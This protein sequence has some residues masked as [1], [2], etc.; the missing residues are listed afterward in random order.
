[1]RRLARRTG[2]RVQI[3]VRTLRHAEVPE[4]LQQYDYFV[5][6][7]RNDTQGVTMCEA[8]ACGMPAVATRVGGIPEFVRDGVDGYLVPPEDPDSLRDAVL[9]LVED[10]S[11]CREMGRNARARIIELCSS[12]KV[13]PRE[14][15]ILQSAAKRT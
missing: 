11:R 6:P 9:R 15:R 7:S 10:P 2:S 8:M 1:L 14:L 12:G 4:L 5:A 3:E 13:I